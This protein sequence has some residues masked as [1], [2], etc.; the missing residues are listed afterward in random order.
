MSQIKAPQIDPGLLK[1]MAQSQSQQTNNLY[2]V[3]TVLVD[4]PL[5]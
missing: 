2:S 4:L 3:P 5:Q 1:M